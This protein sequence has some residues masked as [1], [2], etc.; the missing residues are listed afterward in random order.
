M[1]NLDI[2]SVE[3]WRNKKKLF[4]R[5]FFEIVDF[6]NEK[7]KNSDEGRFFLTSLDKNVFNIPAE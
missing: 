4:K 2:K 7:D 5:Y 1:N 6:K 3:E